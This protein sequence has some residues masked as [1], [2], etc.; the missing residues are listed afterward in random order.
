MT[1]EFA[2]TVE[3]VAAVK[4]TAAV[5]FATSCSVCIKRVKRELSQVLV[6]RELLKCYSSAKTQVM[7]RAS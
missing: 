7:A 6:W 2:S 4:L 5:E 3:F 1:V